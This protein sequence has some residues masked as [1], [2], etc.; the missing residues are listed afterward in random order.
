M[1]CWDK[2]TPIDETMRALDDLVRAGKVRYLGFSDTPAW[3]VAEAQ[4]LA[5]CRHW[6]PLIG[7]QIEYSLLERTVEGE[8][9]PMALEMGLGV[10]PWSPLKSGVLSGK[11]TRANAGQVEAGRGEWATQALNERTYQI[12]DVLLRIARELGSTPARVA[13][14]WVQAQPG[15]TS[16]IIGARTMQ[17]LDDNLGALDVVLQPEHLTALHEVSQPTLNFPAD[18]LVN[19]AN[20]AYGGTTINGRSSVV[21]PLLPQSDDERH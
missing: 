2:T 10:T 12:I 8:L 14:A 13:L 19:V 17:Q 9:I 3:K 15:V 4:V 1:H 18:F 5:H 16:T 7:L 21:L 11:Y 6:S 20:F